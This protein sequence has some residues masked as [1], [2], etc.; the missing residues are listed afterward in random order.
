MIDS[1][2]FKTATRIIVPLSLLLA[3]FLF[4]KGHQTPGGGFV[5]GLVIAVALTIHRISDGG[6]SLDRVLPAPEP[7]LIGIGLALS[8]GTG[9]APLVV[10]LPFLTSTFGYL[11]PELGN[12]EW[13]TVMVFDLGIMLVVTGVVVGIVNAISRELDS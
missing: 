5:G 10:G 3:M 11:P 2:I 8:L 9:M 4:L 7:W 1:L 12:F 6:E 13:T